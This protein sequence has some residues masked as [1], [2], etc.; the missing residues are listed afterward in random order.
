LVNTQRLPLTYT[1]KYVFLGHVFW[2]SNG[3]E[4]LLYGG[5]GVGGGGGGGGKTVSV[6]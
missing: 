1:I 4:K 5:G 6:I 3:E 2:S